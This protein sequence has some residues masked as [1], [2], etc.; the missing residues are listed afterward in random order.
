M[1]AIVVSTEQGKRIEAEK[2]CARAVC[3]CNKHERYC[4]SAYCDC[5]A[6]TC[7]KIKV[8][9]SD[10]LLGRND[11]RLHLSEKRSTWLPDGARLSLELL[12]LLHCGRQRNK[13]THAV[14][15][16][17]FAGLQESQK[18]TF[19]L[20]GDPTRNWPQWLNFYPKIVRAGEKGFLL[21]QFPLQ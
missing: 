2:A 6:R 12:E 10:A 3:V 15:F 20:N 8:Q 19:F 16:V 13:H 5:M 4:I 21:A 17:R 14:H 18:K 11:D 9:S 1:S 7:G